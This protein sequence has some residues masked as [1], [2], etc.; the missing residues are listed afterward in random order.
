MENKNN[1]SKLFTGII[2]ITIGIVWML[3]IAD[4]NIPEWLASWQMLLIGI[5]LFI[6]SQSNFKGTGFL[7]P[8]LIGLFFLADE[9]YLK[10]LSLTKFIWP[11]L[12]I[13]FGVLIIFKPGFK[14]RFSKQS[15]TSDTSTESNQLNLEIIMSGVK[16]S[17]YSDD[18]KGGLIN[19]VMG[20]VDLNLRNI[21]INGTA[22]I[23]TNT[24]LG[25]IKL[26]LPDNVTVKSEMQTILGGIEDKRYNANEN[27]EAILILK[28]SAIL[29]GIEI[30]N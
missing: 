3:R 29:G 21:K 20:G 25:G 10:E 16:K 23:N 22:T 1:S 14:N 12:I 6:G 11:A 15:K 30:C 4:V 27:A 8:L 24:I 7:F 5:G 2:L 18:F 17:I 28:G 19:C 13:I 9:F 26:T